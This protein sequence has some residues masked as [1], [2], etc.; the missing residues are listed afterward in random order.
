M[1]TLIAAFIA[2]SS[3]LIADNSSVVYTEEELEVLAE[4]CFVLRNLRK[5]FS[6]GMIV[7][8]SDI[9]LRTRDNCADI[10]RFFLSLNSSSEYMN[11]YDKA[12]SCEEMMQDAINSNGGLHSLPLPDHLQQQVQNYK[13]DGQSCKDITQELPSK[14]EAMK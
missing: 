10:V 6:G 12:M 9:Q 4:D 5:Q 2:V 14:S 1:K 11:I 8:Y 13:I 3:L 7:L